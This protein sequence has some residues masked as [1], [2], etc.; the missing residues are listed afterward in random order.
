MTI[1]A[2]KQKNRRS[3]P[4]S[5]TVL[6]L[7]A[8]LLLLVL[9]ESSLPSPTTLCVQG[10][11]AAKN[12]RKGGGKNG[13]GNRGSF[14]GFGKPPP[15]L[16]EVLGKISINRA[17][18]DAGAKPCPCGSSKT[19]AE[20]C[21]P[22]LNA[23]SKEANEHGGCQTALEVL[24]SRYSAFCYRNVGHVIRT[25]HRECRDYR[26]DKVAWAKDLDKEGMFDSFEFVGLEILGGGDDNHESEKEEND[27]NE[28]FLEFRVRMRGRSLEESPVRS[29]SVSS[30]EGEETVISERSRFLKDP[31]SGTWKYA[32]GDVRSTVQGLED[33][34]LNV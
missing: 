31:E 14:G 24:Q 2:S 7:L 32:G 23:S 20:C 4:L 16:E 15:T 12:K 33:T 18:E 8:A 10:F 3:H 34:T 25:T 26:D 21:G 1:A 17:P 19:F 9:E 6:L 22:I 28:T 13:K 30:I 11:A 5:A 29:R 27:E